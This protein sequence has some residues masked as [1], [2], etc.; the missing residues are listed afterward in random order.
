MSDSQAGSNQPVGV[1]LVGLGGHGGTIQK[2]TAEAGNLAVRA[3]CDLD[4]D[5]RAGAADRF[6]CDG[7]ESYDAV[8][9]RDDVEAVILVTPNH[10]HRGQAVAALEAGLDVFVEKPIANVVEDGLAMM[11][12][13][14]RSSRILMVGHNM[15]RSRAARKARALLEEGRLGEVVSVDIHFSSDTGLRLQNDSWRLRPGYCPLMPV[16]QLGIHAIDLV[17]YFLAPIASVSARARSVASPPNVQDSVVA[18]FE[19]E[20]GELGT[21]VSNYCTQIA[22]EYRLSG[23]EGSLWGTPH[24]LAWRRREDTDSH[25][26]GPAEEHDFR[27]HGLESY[28]LQ[29]KEFGHAVRSRERPETD[30]RVGL[31]ALSVVEAMRASVES[32]RRESIP[33]FEVI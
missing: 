27:A 13:A 10:L 24:R 14:E 18:T 28:A 12:T 1:A 3:V 23:T 4:A 2:A 17:H 5:Q 9:E 16:M 31:R 20:S 25:G 8:L 15:R 22:F 7:T 33:A 21:M 29:M 26:E 6:G 11:G 30:A 19:T 32:G